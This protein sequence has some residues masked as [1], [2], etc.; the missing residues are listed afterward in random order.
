MHRLPGW[1]CNVQG[2]HLSFGLQHGQWQG[3]RFT[4]A[5]LLR[6]CGAH[7]RHFAACSSHECLLCPMPL[8]QFWSE[9]CVSWSLTSSSVRPLMRG[10]L[11][12]PF[13][14]C[15][16]RQDVGCLSCQLSRLCARATSSTGALSYN[17]KK[18]VHPEDFGCKTHSNTRTCS[19]EKHLSQQSSEPLSC[20]QHETKRL[21]EGR[22]KP[23]TL[24][25]LISPSLFL[26]H[27][28]TE[29]G[30]LEHVRI[31]SGAV[32]RNSLGRPLRLQESKL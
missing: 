10:Q 9:M 15:M 17:F 30:R 3:A 32:F 11:W 31:T 23:T 8:S 24:L 1:P 5:F 12:M 18:S 20:Q 28:L 29:L 26:R 21:Q 4:S 2:V 14:R 19:F 25:L 16:V 13:R 27:G 22:V 7:H 6:S